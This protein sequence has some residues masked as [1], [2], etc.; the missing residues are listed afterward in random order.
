MLKFVSVL[1]ISAAVCSAAF[2][3]ETLTIHQIRLGV[4][5]SNPEFGDAGINREEVNQEPITIELKKHEPQGAEEGVS[6]R[7]TYTQKVKVDKVEYEVSVTVSSNLKTDGSRGAYQLYGTVKKPG[8]RWPLSMV[9]VIA[10]DL[11]GLQ[12]LMEVSGWD[13]KPFE[14]KS[15]YKVNGEEKTFTK[16]G[17][18]E[19]VVAVNNYN[20]FE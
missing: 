20:P 7:G 9:S 17:S 6:Y 14:Y 11:K 13:R 4:E 15:V 12:G 8:D 1:F 5:Y 19:L 3:A 2:S 16:T 10:K 18:L